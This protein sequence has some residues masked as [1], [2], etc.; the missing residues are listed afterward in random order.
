MVNSWTT[1]ESKI[2]VKGT[3]VRL[4]IFVPWPF[5]DMEDPEDTQDFYEYDLSDVF[6]P[7]DGKFAMITKIMN[8]LRE[9]G[10]SKMLNLVT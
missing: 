9:E 2:W 7:D 1:H 10:T 8:L 6:T 5:C 3:R 4:N